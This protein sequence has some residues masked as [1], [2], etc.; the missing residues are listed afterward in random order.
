MRPDSEYRPSPNQRRTRFS[1]R[2]TLTGAAVVGVAVGGGLLSRGASANDVKVNV[3]ADVPN[4]IRQLTPAEQAQFRGDP[5]PGCKSWGQYADE[6]DKEEKDGK[7][8]EGTGQDNGV[9]LP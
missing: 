7:V 2:T 3:C 1:L 6:L 5:P 9:T 4:S 8:I